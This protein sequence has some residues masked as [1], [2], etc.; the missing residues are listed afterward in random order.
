MIDDDDDELRKISESLLVRVNALALGVV[1]GLVA[2]LGLFAAT[3]WLLIKGGPDPGPHLGLL[4]QYFYGYRVSF[5][6]SLIGFAW[7]FAIAFLGTYA[8]AHIYNVV[9][10]WRAKDERPGAS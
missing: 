10:V 3:N 6:G 8:G 2:G 4:G 9:A 5:A 1:A 7:A